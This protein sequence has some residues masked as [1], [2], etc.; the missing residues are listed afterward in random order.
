MSEAKALDE[1]REHGID[2]GRDGDRQ[3]TR[4]DHTTEHT[5]SARTLQQAIGNAQLS[6]VLRMADPGAGMTSLVGPNPGAPA[7]NSQNKPKQCHC[8]G[9]SDATDMCAECAEQQGS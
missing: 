7:R 3:T 4:A 9:A 2:A 8:D 5:H 6:R 1:G